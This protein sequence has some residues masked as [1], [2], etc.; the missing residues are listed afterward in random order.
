MWRCLQLHQGWQKTCLLQAVWT[1]CQLSP[2]DRCSSWL[3]SRNF[4]VTF[5]M[6]TTRQRSL[7]YPGSGFWDFKRILIVF[8]LLVPTSLPPVG[9]CFHP[10]AEHSQDPFRMTG[11]PLPSGMT[12]TQSMKAP[13]QTCRQNM[14]NKYNDKSKLFQSKRMLLP[15]FIY[16]S[17]GGIKI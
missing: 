1:G 11:T 17:Q 2:R 10:Q 9:V 5:E 8:Q 15:T 13:I 14:N 12:F 16:L 3:S 7:H 6:L 4:P